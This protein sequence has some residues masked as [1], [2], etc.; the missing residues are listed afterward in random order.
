[1][2]DT[3]NSLRGWITAQNHE[4]DLHLEEPA[5]VRGDPMAIREVVRNLVENAVKHTPAGTAIRVAVGPDSALTVE[6][7][8]PGVVSEIL[9]Q[10]S[11]SSCLLLVTAGSIRACSSLF[12]KFK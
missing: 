2:W 3:I 8:G 1:M 10:L 7:G 4:I 6:D 11:S 9:E 5:S 12:A